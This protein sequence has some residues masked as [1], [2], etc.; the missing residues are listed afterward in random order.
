MEVGIDNGEIR[1]LGRGIDVRARWYNPIAAARLWLFVILKLLS[2]VSTPD[3]WMDK[4]IWVV[5]SA[6]WRYAGWQYQYR[7]M[8]VIMFSRKCRMFWHRQ[9]FLPQRS[10]V[11]KVAGRHGLSDRDITLTPRVEPWEH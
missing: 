3:H 5:G 1:E 7:S 11:E 6:A 9:Q 4:L 10:R 8:E 2:A